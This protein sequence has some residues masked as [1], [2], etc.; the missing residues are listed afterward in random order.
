MY[1][2]NEHMDTEIKNTIPFN[3]AFKHEILRCVIL[4]NHVQAL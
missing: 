2:S 1:T 4:T 3:I